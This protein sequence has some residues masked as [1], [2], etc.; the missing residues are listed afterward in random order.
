MEVI[1]GNK[2]PDLFDRIKRGDNCHT[3]SPFANSPGKWGTFLKSNNVLPILFHTEEWGKKNNGMSAMTADAHHLL[4]IHHG[5]QSSVVRIPGP[6]VYTRRQRHLYPVVSSLGCRFFFVV[7]VVVT[8][9]ACWSDEDPTD[10]DPPTRNNSDRR[11]A[12]SQH[13]CSSL[14]F[15]RGISVAAVVES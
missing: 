13:F 1:G 8:Y 15:L 12:R 6:R 11:L 3:C 10:D 5:I 2:A 9:R 7:V 4:R 14:R